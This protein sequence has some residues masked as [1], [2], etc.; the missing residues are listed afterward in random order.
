MGYANAP[1]VLGTLGAT[2]VALGALGLPH[3]AGGV[4]A[5]PAV[6]AGHFTGS[7]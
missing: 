2:E 5:A 6:M 7:P 1:M 4:G 3:R